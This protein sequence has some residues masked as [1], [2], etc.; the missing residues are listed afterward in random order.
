MSRRPTPVVFDLDGVLVDPEPAYEA[1]SKCI[2]P[3]SVA[4][5]SRACSLSP[6]AAARRSS[7]P[8]WRSISGG[9]PQT[10]RPA[11]ER[12]PASVFDI[13]RVELI[14]DP[15]R[16]SRSALLGVDIFPHLMSW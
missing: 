6:A 4:A 13:Q 8:S 16:S 9:R 11:S 15:P 14:L 1:A 3:R 2:W 12:P 5:T 7:P 10:S